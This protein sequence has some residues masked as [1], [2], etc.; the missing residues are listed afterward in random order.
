[1]S[2]QKNIAQFLNNV[3]NA[4]K[5]NDLV[6]DVREALMDY[7]VCASKCLALPTSNMFLRLPC[8]VIPTATLTG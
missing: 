7:Q 3:Q 8:N 6:D 4:Q 1:M 5:L 2:A